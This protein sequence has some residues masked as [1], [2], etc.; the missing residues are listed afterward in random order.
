MKFSAREDIE[1]PIAHVHAAITDFA[2]FERQAMRRGAEVRRLD[3]SGPA[4]Q[5]SQW[6]VAFSFRGRDRKLRATLAQ[7][8]PQTVR[9]R[10]ESPGLDGDLAIELVPLSAK[11]TRMAVVIEMKAKTLTARLM[12]QSLKLAKANLA[13]RFKTR[14]ADHA[15][16]IEARYRG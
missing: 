14:V 11:R 8:D 9:M 1:A 16:D 13:Q 7:V 2:S 10:T 15:K 6:D 3:G 5:G 12:L 4:G